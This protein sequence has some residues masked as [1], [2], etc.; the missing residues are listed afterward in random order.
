[1]FHPVPG[2][3]SPLADFSLSYM[4]SMPIYLLMLSVPRG[5]IIV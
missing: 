5:D 2:N 1:M 3:L 4:N